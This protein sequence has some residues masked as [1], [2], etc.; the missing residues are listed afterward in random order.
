MTLHDVLYVLNIPFHLVS[1]SKVRKRNYRIII[2]EEDEAPGGVKLEMFHK[3]TF[4]VKMVGV[5]TR[6]GLYEA[7][8]RVFMTE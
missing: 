5:E 1:I 7:V 4:G 3:P 6:E 2:D 8:L